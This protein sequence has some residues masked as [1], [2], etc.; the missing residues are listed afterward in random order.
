M[1]RWAKFGAGPLPRCLRGTFAEDEEVYM[2]LP[3]YER[4]VSNYI[5][6]LKEAHREVMLWWSRLLAEASPEGNME[7]AE[8][9]VRPRW[10]VGPTSHPRIIAVYRKYYLEVEKI[11]EAWHKKR[12]EARQAAHGTWGTREPAEEDGI[13]E[14]RFLLIDDLDSREPE[15]HR[16]INYMIFSPIGTNY[17]GDAA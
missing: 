1:R 6:D 4:I 12:D 17:E 2:T 16:F 11:N 15:L 7:I 8:K 3:K 5:A 9:E 13:I 14:P 10:P